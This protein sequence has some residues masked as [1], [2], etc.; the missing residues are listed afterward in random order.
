MRR[1]TTFL[2]FASLSIAGAFAQTGFVGT[3]YYRIRNYKTERYIYVTDNTDVSNWSSDTED[4]QAIQLW[5]GAN[6]AVSDPASVIYAEQQ[7]SNT[8]DLQAQ[9]TGLKTLTGH[10]VTVTKVRNGYEVSATQSG[11][12]KYLSDDRTNNTERG[13]LGTREGGDNRK[14]VVDKITTNHA[15]NYFGIKPTIQL[16]GKWYQPFYAAF[17]FKTASANMHVYYVSKVDGSEATLKEIVGE[18]PASTP[19][20]IECASEN[21]SENRLELLSSSS[22]KVTGNKLA[23]VYFCNP[24]R[25]NSAKAYTVFNASTMRVLTTVDGKLVMTNNAPERLTVLNIF[26]EI[27]EDETPTPCIPANTSYLNVGTGTPKV[28]NISIDGSGI[29]EIL[30]GSTDESVEGVYT[31]SG[32]QLRPTNDATGL[33]AGIYIIGGHKFVIK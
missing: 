2:F 9:G 18:V 15:T 21:T 13:K 1:L 29:D 26:D 24:E 32:T 19:V 31:L 33:P 25:P 3:D 10:Y 27:T 11:V 17:P 22:A 4:F 14:W 28:L 8:F 20:I 7:S 23:G 30:A 16:N 12:T 6:K 5:K